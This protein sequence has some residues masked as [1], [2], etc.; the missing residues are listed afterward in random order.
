[1]AS[2]REKKKNGKTVSF[3]FT[4]CFGRDAHGKQIRRYSTWIPTEGLTPSKARKA[5]EKAADAWEEV[6][7]SE[8]EK[9]LRNPERVMTKEL[10]N[11]KM[12]FSCF[13]NDVWFPLRIDNGE[14]KAKTVSYYSS[15]AKNIVSYFD[16]VSI[17]K[18]CSTDIQ[19]FLNYLHTEKQYSAQYVQHHYRCLKVIFDFSISQGVLFENPM[20][21]VIKPKLQKKKVDALSQTEARRFFD[22][23]GSVP[24][25]FRCLLYLMVSVGLRRGECL[26]LQ[27]G[28]ID[29]VCSTIKIE[30]NVVYS[31]KTGVVVNTPKTAASVRI[32]PVLPSVLALLRE[33]KHQRQRENP[34]VILEK[35][36]IFPSKQD[37]FKA[38]NPDAVTRRTKR[39]MKSIGINSYSPHDLRHSAASL[40]LSSGA[41]IK[42][43]QEILGHASA[44][45]TLNFYVKSDIKQMKA[46]TEKMAMAFGL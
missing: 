23:L 41:D 20:E 24:L 33:L 26:G 8:Y 16:G 21:R 37:V 9:D 40:M 19:R 39:L 12:N 32:I 14:N 18:I 25:D 31:A 38:R 36:Y 7:R 5:A 17:Q 27:W 3:Q 43:V 42:S 4:C 30:R 34:N 45:T 22:V 10:V 11:S 15:T 46:A 29:E 28:D 2:I 13:I 44:S 6:M 1:M 35:S